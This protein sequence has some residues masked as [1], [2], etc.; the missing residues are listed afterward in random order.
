MRRPGH[1]FLATVLALVTT[2]LGSVPIAAVDDPQEAHV[3]E[4]KLQEELHFRR[5]F[6]FTTDV[7]TVR[8][9]MADPTAYVR[10]PAALTPTEAAEM[11]RRLAMEEEMLPLG[12]LAEALP[13]YAGHWIDQP[14]GGIIV[15]AFTSSGESHR[16]VLQA[17][18]PA[19]AELDLVEV[20]H[21]LAHLL[22]VEEQI[23]KDRT[24]LRE[25]GVTLGHW[26]WM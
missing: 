1:L 16:A 17:L 15:V 3:D 2:L 18:V 23:T 5:N 6:G 12:A 13:D 8:Q 7:V 25:H 20:T 11:D 21:P 19:G 9:L 14:A 22:A 24:E 26:G 10:W 4:Q